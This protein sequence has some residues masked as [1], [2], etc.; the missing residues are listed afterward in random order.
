MPAV[1]KMKVPCSERLVELLSPRPKKLDTQGL[2]ASRTNPIRHVEFHKSDF[3][4][5]LLHVPIGHTDIVENYFALAG[6]PSVRYTR[7]SPLL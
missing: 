6:R 1:G 3:G 2:S 5:I 4:P 7:A